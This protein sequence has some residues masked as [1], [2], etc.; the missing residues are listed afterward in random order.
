M[1]LLNI[2]VIKGNT[3]KDMIVSIPLWHVTL[4]DV[5]PM[6]WFSTGF[7]LKKSSISL[8]ADTIKDWCELY[9]LAQRRVKKIGW[10][11]Q[12]IENKR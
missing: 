8:H 7:V 2:R 6:M 12:H 9:E 10:S 3:K 4:R 5:K 11:M 1:G